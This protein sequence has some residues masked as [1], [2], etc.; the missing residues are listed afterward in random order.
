MMNVISG[1]VLFEHGRE[2]LCRLEGGNVMLGDNQRG[3]L[4]DVACGLLGAFLHDEAAEAAKKYI[5]ATSKGL[6]HHDHESL[7]RVEDSTLVLPCELGNLVD[8]LLLSHFSFSFD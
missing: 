6:L 1:C 8:N 3:I 7:N 4:A 2:S 5:L